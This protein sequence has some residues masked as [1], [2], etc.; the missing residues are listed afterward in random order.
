MINDLFIELDLIK[1]HQN[2]SIL[3]IEKIE[4]LISY[5]SFEL[6]SYER[7][8]QKFQQISNPEKDKNSSQENEKEED[9]GF[10]F[11]IFF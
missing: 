4:K 1:K 9:G 6:S 10:F 5:L 3:E 2:L 8:Y 7:I 11:P